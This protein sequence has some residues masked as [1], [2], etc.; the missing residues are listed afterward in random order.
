[1]TTK[2]TKG[3][4]LARIYPIAAQ[5][6]SVAERLSVDDL[7]DKMAELSGSKLHADCLEGRGTL[8]ILP[9]SDPIRSRYRQVK[10]ILR[11]DL[12]PEGA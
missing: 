11:K 5:H 3:S 10:G 12:G 7:A 8:A 9:Q 2:T 1:M 6:A 4:M